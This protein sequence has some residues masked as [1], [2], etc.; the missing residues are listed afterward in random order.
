MKVVL[1]SE[2]ITHSNMLEMV[3]ST[4]QHNSRIWKSNEHASKAHAT[5]FIIILELAKV[6]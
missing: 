5:A 6:T 4:A 1:L 2:Y 3:L